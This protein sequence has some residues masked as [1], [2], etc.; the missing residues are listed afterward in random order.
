MI[1]FKWDENKNSK[2]VQKHGVSFK[3][4]LT[5]FYDDSALL[6][7]DDSHSVDEDR[8]ILIGLSNQGRI[9]VVCHAYYEEKEIIRIISSREATKKETLQYLRKKRSWKKNTILAKAKRIHTPT[10]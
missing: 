7:N 8:F 5:V 10:N 6:I 1:V 9:L 3:E 4:S 2:N